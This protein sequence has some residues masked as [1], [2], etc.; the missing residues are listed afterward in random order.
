MIKYAENIEYSSCN[1]DSYEDLYV[2]E[3]KTLSSTLASV[4]V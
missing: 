2:I 4:I 3:L 1:S